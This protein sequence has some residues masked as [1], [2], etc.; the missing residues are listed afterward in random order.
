MKYFISFAYNKNWN[1]SSGFMNHGIEMS[2][3][4]N[5]IEIVNEM[6]EALKKRLGLDV[7]KIISW[8]RFEDEDAKP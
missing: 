5:S 6:E 3:K 4:I 8:Q 7:V 2:S 1:N